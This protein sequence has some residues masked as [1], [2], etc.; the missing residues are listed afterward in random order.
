[1]FSFFVLFSCPSCSARFPLFYSAALSLL[2][3]LRFRRGFAQIH[4]FLLHPFGF[5]LSAFSLRGLVPFFLPKV[6]FIPGLPLGRRTR[7]LRRTFF[8][9]L[10]AQL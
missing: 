9:F 3:L 7:S 6:R 4:P 1:L 2:S 10:G 5:S 8:H